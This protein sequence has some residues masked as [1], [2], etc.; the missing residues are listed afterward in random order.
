[1]ALPNHIPAGIAAVALPAILFFGPV[2]P[3][4]AQSRLYEEAPLHY[5]DSKAHDP[6]AKL[7]QRH[8]RG[9]ITFSGQTD[10]AFLEEFLHELD[11]PIESQVLVFSKT[12]KQNRLITPQTP[13]AIYFSEEFYVG[14]VPGGMIEIGSID[15]KIGPIFYLLEHRNRVEEGLHFERPQDCLDCHAG[16]RTRDHPGFLV[17]SVFPDEDGLPLFS[18]G[19]F[20]TD[21]TSPL[22]QRWGGWYVTG[23][24]GEQPHMG[25]TIASID[26]ENLIFDIEAGANLESLDSFF[27]TERYLSPHSD[28]LALMVLEHQTEMHNRLHRAAAAFNRVIYLQSSLSATLNETPSKKLTGSALSVAEGETE[29]ILE[30]LLFCDEAPL[31]GGI[32]G[33]G[34]FRDAFLHNRRDSPDG[35]SLKDFQLLDRLFKY[36]C[37]YMIYS[38]S[39]DAL[40][41]PLKAMVYRR[42]WKIL[43]GKDPEEKFHHFSESERLRIKEILVNTKEDLPPYW[44]L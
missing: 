38:S 18:E 42:L 32:D 12:S 25:N 8:R 44:K 1:M 6:I 35:R 17:R 11:I 13:R 7:S 34:A 4:G 21:H 41:G 5:S 43:Q 28:I 24:H 39:F 26:G 16:S 36:R 9:E 23:R 10:K 30:Y 15:P 3:S 2:A 31:E 40:P 33:G 27:P 20:L 19:S 29:R 14:W 22:D 37:S